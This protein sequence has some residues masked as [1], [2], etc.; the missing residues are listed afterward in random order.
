VTDS[1]DFDAD[2]VERTV[3]VAQ[4]VVFTIQPAGARLYT[5]DAPHFLVASYEGGFDVTGHE[6][7]R[8]GAGLGLLAPETE[9]NTV[10]LE[11]DPAAHD[12][13]VFE[14]Q[15]RVIDMEEFPVYSD[16]AEVEIAKPMTV[17]SG[18]T[19]QEA[20][21]GDEVVWKVEVSGGLGTLKY[22]WFLDRKAE[23]AFMP[24]QDGAF[25]EGAFA[26]SDTATL[27]LVPF[28]SGMAGKY[29]V[30]VSD[31]LQTITVGPASLVE[32]TGIP[33][34]SALGIAVL[35]LATALGGA[36]ALRK[37]D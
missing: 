5:S 6:W 25:G 24:V 4:Q 15:L 14:Y 30:E 21:P 16:V 20:K 8:D 13:G 1:S 11:I 32:G 17:D 28:V 35:A 34:A 18:L 2:T 33:A 31:D 27:Q 29:K 12:L 23:K 19:D 7:L 10:G 37:R 26:G 22:Q 36:R 3:V 9:G